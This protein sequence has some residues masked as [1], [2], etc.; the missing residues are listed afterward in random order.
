MDIEH[1]NNHL[2]DALV[3]FHDII[4]GQLESISALEAWLDDRCTSDK[5]YKDVASAIETVLVSNKALLS[6]ARRTNAWPSPLPSPSYYELT[7]THTTSEII[8]VTGLGE[9]LEIRTDD[10]TSKV[11]IEAFMSTVANAV[12]ALPTRLALIASLF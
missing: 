8:S 4:D 1:V 2:N 5:I 3:A 12:C 9:H 7:W 11:S 6:E 10:H